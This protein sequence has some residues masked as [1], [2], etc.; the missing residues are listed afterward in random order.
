ML[1]LRL[2]AYAI[3]TAAGVVVGAISLPLTISRST[4][5]ALTMTHSVLGG[6][7]LGVYLNAALNLGIP[8]P[9]T[10]TLTSILLS[11]LAAEFSERIFSEDVA[12]ALA[13]AIATTITI[14]FSYLTIQ[15]SSTGISQAWLYIAGTSAIATIDDLLR[16]ISA[17]IVVVPLVHLISR[18]LK[19]I[20]FDR[21]GAAAM[22][23]S[24]RLYR[25]L[26]FSLSAFAA[27]TLAST[28]GVLATHVMLAVPGALSARLGGRSPYAISY[29]SAILIALSGY[30]LA[31]AMGIPPSGGIGIISALMIPGMVLKHGR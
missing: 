27:S 2:L 17:A 24:P 29:A 22:G 4:L 31:Q 8:V 25:Y 9:I 20:A 5:F 13:V 26:F 11:I 7:I 3:A 14:I 19:Y 21:D 6:A 1:E 18:E 28:I 23:L 30:L 15:L 12:T 16:M 10:A